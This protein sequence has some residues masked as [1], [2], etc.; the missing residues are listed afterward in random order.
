MI[1][2]SMRVMALFAIVFAVA[3]F[4][5]M[6][7]T[8]HAAPAGTIYNSIPSPLPG[9]LPSVGAEAYAF[10]EFGNQVVFAGTARA[11]SNVVVVTSSW[12]CQTGHWYSGDCATTPGA[13]YNMPITLNI[14]NVGTDG[15]SVGSL[16]TSKTTTFA[17]PYRPS[18][19]PRCSG[20]RWYSTADSTCYNGFASTITFDFS[21]DNVTLPDKVIYGIQYNTSHY[22]PNP[23]G[24]SAPC[25]T[26]SG[27]CFYDSLN[28]A[29]SAD[30]DVS[31]GYDPYP[32][33]VY[34]NSPYG[35]Q[36]CDGGLAGQGTFRLDSPTTPCWTNLV[37]AVQFNA[38]IGP[39]TSMDQC[40][41]GGWQQFNNPSFKNQGD[42]VSYVATHG[43][44]P[45]NGK[46]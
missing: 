6:S 41:N 35:S 9:N 46:P 40:K 13:T 26:S 45:G 30:S 19:D 33:T 27:G 8:A 18:A 39:P 15:T 22:G 28:I 7:G 42:C 12:A 20:G 23:I 38:L 43:K 14:Y 44:N 4:G 16:I 34:Q 36:Y 2:K 21:S 5:S 3:V 24:E 37:P 11:L 25:Y 17:I 29:L 10:N 1:V 31:T 32:D